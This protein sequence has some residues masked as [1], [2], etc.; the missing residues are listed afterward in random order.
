MQFKEELLVGRGGDRT[1][2][3]GRCW[4]VLSAWT[5]PGPTLVELDKEERVCE[6]P[7]VD[8]GLHQ[9]YEGHDQEADE[10]EGDEGPQVMPGHP[11]PVAQAAEP[12]LLP[13]VGRVAGGV[14]DRSAIGGLLV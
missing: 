8:D 9:V 3:L 13:G 12:A 2:N 10:E 5:G 14:W 6:G 1:E 4:G 11:D 7:P